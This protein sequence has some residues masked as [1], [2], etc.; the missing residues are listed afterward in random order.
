MLLWLHS[1]DGGWKE[2]AGWEIFL[3]VEN[4]KQYNPEIEVQSPYPGVFI[5]RFENGFNYANQQHHLDGLLRYVQR[6]TRCAQV[7]AHGKP[8]VCSIDMAAFL[9]AHRKC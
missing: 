5:F 2:K 8:A 9:G 1:N 6:E 3:P 7:D 4:N